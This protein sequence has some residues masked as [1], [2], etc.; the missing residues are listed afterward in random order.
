MKIDIPTALTARESAALSRMAQGLNVVEAGSLLGY[1]TVVMAQRA[2]HVVA[3]DPHDGYP[4]SAPRPTLPAFL[5]NLKRHGVRSRVTPIVSAADRVLRRLAA[6]AV[7]LDLTGA[8][9]V[10]HRLTRDALRIAPVVAVHDYA[11][12]GC[13]GAT[14]AVDYLVRRHRLTVER[15]DTLVILRPGHPKRP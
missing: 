13:H 4:F 1:S 15:V 5:H 9:D 3:I 2:R 6:D 8:Y 7:F 10:T 11:R 12:G 14:E